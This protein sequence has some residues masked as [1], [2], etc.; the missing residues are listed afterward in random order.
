MT[1]DE[2]SKYHELKQSSTFLRQRIS[3][4]SCLMC[5]FTQNTKNSRCDTYQF[6]HFGCRR[7]RNVH[8]V[9][10]GFQSCHVWCAVHRNPVFCVEKRRNEEFF[11]WKV[12]FYMCV[13]ACASVHVHTQKWVCANECV[14][15]YT[16]KHIYLFIICIYVRVCV[17]CMHVSLYLRVCACLCVC[18][19]SGVLYGM[20]WLRLIGSLKL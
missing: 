6:L 15:V 10:G 8:L 14:D 4:V 20:G 19:N 12:Y 18:V 7:R 2:S 3:V 1:N 16:H 17:F 5:F 9:V 11:G 13:C